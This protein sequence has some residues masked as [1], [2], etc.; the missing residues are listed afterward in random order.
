[1]SKKLQ[2]NGL[3]ESSRMM[4]PQHKE[5]SMLLDQAKSTAHAEPPTKKDLDLMRDYILLPIALTIVEKKRRET[6][7]SSLTLKILYAAA[8]K[9]LV[10]HIQEDVQQSRKALVEKNIRVV[11]E[12][13][14]PAEIVYRYWCR[15]HEDRFVMTK[16]YMRSEISVRIERYVRSLTSTLQ[17]RSGK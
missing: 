3:W 6:E 2:G 8:A 4:L 1:M 17:E 11:E 9:I 16:D 14:D 5:Q 7:L 15:G 13:K 12:S 10:K